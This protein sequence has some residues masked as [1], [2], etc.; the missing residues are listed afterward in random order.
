MTLHADLPPS[1]TGDPNAPP[2]PLDNPVPVSMSIEAE[3]TQLQEKLPNALLSMFK[4]E[5][6]CGDNLEITNV[7]VTPAGNSLAIR[8]DGHYVRWLCTYA[9]LPQITCGSHQECINKPPETVCWTGQQCLLGICTDVPQCELRGGGQACTDVPDCTNHGMKTVRT[10]HNI[11]LQQSGSISMSLAPTVNNGQ[12]IAVT[13]TVTDVHLNGFAQTLVNLLN[14]NLKSKAQDILDEI[15]DENT[16]SVSLPDELKDVAEIS[17]AH[18]HTSVD[19]HLWLS[20]SGSFQ[21]DSQKALILCER[22]WQ[23]GNCQLK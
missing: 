5:D 17:E 2:A 15:V 12:A 1:P 7:N 9:D 8:T 22:F 14:I 23:K 19:G 3:L 16:F 18:F 13:A 11:V 4:V 10:T 21:I 20:G 6:D